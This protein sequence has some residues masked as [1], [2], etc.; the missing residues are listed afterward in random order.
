[1]CQWWAAVH[2]FKLEVMSNLKFSILNLKLGSSDCNKSVRGIQA[3]AF[4]LNNSPHWWWQGWRLS[5]WRLAPSTHAIP[6][7]RCH[8]MGQHIMKSLISFAY[9]IRSYW[10]QWAISWPK[11]GVR[12]YFTDMMQWYQK[13]FRMI[14][15]D[16]IGNIITKIAQKARNLVEKL[17]IGE[18][19]KIWYHI[20]Y[21]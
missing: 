17:I 9:D 12:S 4:Q 11:S 2:K 3:V 8:D 5:S 14:R 6:P 7:H 16:I 1:M 10:C 21:N 15:Y 13:R 19:T 18:L 20:W